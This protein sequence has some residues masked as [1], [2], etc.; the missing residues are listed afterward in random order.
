M[1]R[2]NLYLGIAIIGFTLALLNQFNSDNQPLANTLYLATVYVIA[3]LYLYD[4]MRFYR[5]HNA[6][7]ASSQFILIPGALMIFSNWLAPQSLDG[8]VLSFDIHNSFMN[9]DTVST[10]TSTA[11]LIPMIIFLN[12]MTKFYQKRYSGFVIR[13]KIFGPVK[14]PFLIHVSVVGGIYLVQRQTGILD[15]VLFVFYLWSVGMIIVYLILPVLRD[16]SDHTDTRSRTEYMERVLARP[17]VGGRRPSTRSDS[18]S[19][20]QP[21]RRSGN[22]PVSSRSGSRTI[23]TQPTGGYRVV[24]PTSSRSNSSS[25]PSARSD[26][27]PRRQ[28]SSSGNRRSVAEID[29]GI[30]MTRKPREIVANTSGK[31]KKYLPSGVVTRDDLKCMVCY[32]D[33]TKGSSQSVSICPY[34][35]FPAHKGELSMW[36]TSSEFCPRCNKSLVGNGSASLISIKENDYCKIRDSI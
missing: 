18:T 7:P 2:V 30:S 5:S 24:S 10:Q 3:L 35:R 27:I 15:F 22:I 8:G 12:L 13:R 17:R 1:R 23:S 28:S 4:E 16:Q 34:C 19:S 11:I 21:R 26:P 36:L 29:E 32:Q 31:G 6:I 33:F 9:V 14:L 25:R 20:P